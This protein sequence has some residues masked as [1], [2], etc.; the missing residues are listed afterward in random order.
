MKKRI[1]KRI[2]ITA[3][4]ACGLG[5]GAC[6]DYLDILPNDKQTTDMFWKK[7]GDVESI[8][9]EGYYL[10][11]TC[12]PNMIYWGEVRGGS[13]I[14]MNTTS[15]NGKIQEFQALADNGNV[16]WETFYQ[17]INMA[18]LVLK[19][20]PSVVDED[21]SYTENAMKSHLTEAYF[22]RGL[23]YLYLVR[24]FKEVPL[25]LE[26][27][28][29]DEM[30]FEVPKSTEEEIL[31][32]IKAD[33]AAALATNACRE[34]NTHDWQTKGRASIWA[35]YS[36]LAETCLWEGDYQ[37]CIDNAD[38]VINSSGAMRPVF[39]GT[40]GQ[41]F[42]IFFQWDGLGSNESIF[43][44]MFD[45]SKPQNS[46]ANSPTNYMKFNTGGT[47]DLI[48][49][50]TMTQRLEEECLASDEPNRSYWGSVA[51]GT[52]D[53][54]PVCTTDY[55]ENAMIWRYVGMGTQD[56]AGTR[57]SGG[58]EA[59][60]NWIIY[61]L[62][63]IMLMKAE[64][65]IFMGGEA[66]WQQ[67]LDILNEIRTRSNLAELTVSFSETDTWGMLELL[68]NERDME[69]AAEGKRWYDLLRVAKQNNH[70][71]KENVISLIIENR[72]GAS[73]KWM[74]SVL[75]NDYAWY[76]PIYQD[77]ITSNKLLLQNPYYDQ[78]QTQN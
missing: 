67:A 30:D 63:D 14:T 60:A 16:K 5:L 55:P 68:L 71:F 57:G 23:M 10:M 26:P 51:A 44:I 52:T 45:Q 69:M 64:A 20:A 46:S 34:P 40:A 11:R 31:A 22:M 24:N 75:S 28:D 27:Y 50:E 72:G 43:E 49:S 35:I 65:L 39:L 7:S 41:W 1:M 29:T 76:L 8:L 4:V 32:Q 74:N 66:N 56:V 36:L 73:T 2:L 61:R 78:T 62:S 42:E 33:C 47:P 6:S 70:E 12:V 25:I 48:F 13:V 38:K 19:Y 37:G 77:E 21:D 18:N 9:G 54:L 53:K 3:S 59:D 17:V 58:N 15:G